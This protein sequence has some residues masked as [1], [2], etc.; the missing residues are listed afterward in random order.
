MGKRLRLILVGM[1]FVS[2]SFGVVSA[3]EVPFTVQTIRVE[4]MPTYD[5][6]LAPDGRTAAIY[7]GPTS[8]SLLNLPLVEYRVDENLLPIRLI[9]LAT[10]SEIVRLSGPTDY[11]TDVA[12]TPDGTRLASYHRNGDIYLW[13]LA[14][15]ESIQRLTGLMGSARLAFLPD[16]QTLVAYM[17]ISLVGHFLLWDMDSQHMTRIWRAPYRSLG[18][19]QLTQVPAN[20]DY[21]YPVFA[22]SPDGALLATATA[23]GEVVVWDTTTLQQ[24]VVQ[25]KAARE[26]RFN[27]RSV[28]F[29][30]SSQTLVY[31]DSLSEQTHFWDVAAQSEAAAIAS[32][33]P[34]FGV[35]PSGD[36]IAWAT[37]EA[38]WF[39]RL[40]QPNLATK[41]LDF[42]DTI[43]VL[44][45]VVTFIDDDRFIVG[46][47]AENSEGSVIYLIALR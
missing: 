31:F 3:Q 7:I 33:S 43:Q 39:A 10:G 46:G 8:Q 12:F 22:V 25:P 4:D 45:P 40:D 28:V 37:R 15:G 41:V 11:I 38:I 14:S 21:R 2:I 30:G 26:G 24:T 5:I 44:A 35:A 32:G 13:D 6:K 36:T 1:L 47:G 9:D 20:L 18:D 17:D 27:V 29:T 19:L 42:P 16:G 23:N 34:F